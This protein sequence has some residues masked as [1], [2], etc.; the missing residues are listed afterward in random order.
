MCAVPAKISDA[1]LTGAAAGLA[2]MI[3]HT[4]PFNLTGMPALALPTGISAERA[5]LSMQLIGKPFDEAAIIRVGDA[6]ERARGAMPEAQFEA[7]R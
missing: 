7:A 1:H 4:A 2:E 6:Y 5:P 3:R